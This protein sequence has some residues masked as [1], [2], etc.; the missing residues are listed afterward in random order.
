M[1]KP[2][3]PYCETS[4][5][6]HQRYEDTANLIFHQQQKKK[7]RESPGH[8][9]EP[10]VY[11]PYLPADGGDVTADSAAAAAAVDFSHYGNTGIVVRKEVLGQTVNSMSTPTRRER[12]PITVERKDGQVV[13]SRLCVLM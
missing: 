6:I 8:K 7:K 2:P 4:A 9:R 5:Y 3:V 10:V 11:K 12:V 13:Q 1:N